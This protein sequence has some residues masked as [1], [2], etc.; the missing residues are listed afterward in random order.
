[1]A[2]DKVYEQVVSY[3]KESIANGNLKIG[4]A[5]YSENL[6]CEKLGVSRTSVRKAIRLMIEENI[7]VSCQGKGTFIKARGCGF[8]HNALCLVNHSSRALRYDVTDSYYTDIIYS[9]EAAT[10]DHDLEFQIFSRNIQTP[11]E[12]AERFRKLK[13]DGLLIDASYQNYFDS[14]ECFRQISPN[15]VVV[16]GNP[17]ETELPTV[18]PD[19]QEGYLLLLEKAKL[20]G[21]PVAFLYHD[22]HATH[23]WRYECFRA[24]AAEAGVEAEYL[25]YGQNI[26][27]DNFMSLDGYRRDHHPL[28]Y[29]TLKPWLTPGHI[30]GT[31]LCSCDYAAAKVL[32]ILTRC[33]YR[34]PDDFGV[35][36][37][38]GFAFSSMTEPEITTVKV[39]SFE[40][41]RLSVELLVKCINGE[42]PALKRELLPP[43]LLK[44][45]SL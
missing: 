8:M 42:A 14:L 41:G 29:N 44:R 45:D 3:L 15:L 16:D 31:I 23:R 27:F 30:G 21:G 28:I 32:Q 9:T 17:N 34:T 7:L 10:R 11:A 12:I 18:A 40:L 39:D 38:G 1:M 43:G 26:S 25:N 36:G 20:R 5:I 24:A 4:D 35:A 33:G 2:G 19:A 6:L 37:F 22:L 13:F